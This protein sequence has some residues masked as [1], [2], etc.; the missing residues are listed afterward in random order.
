MDVIFEEDK[1]FWMAVN[2]FMQN[3]KCPIVLIS[4]GQRLPAVVTKYIMIIPVVIAELH[5]RSA[6]ERS[7][8]PSENFW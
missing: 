1:S 6:L 5:A 4:T 7:P 2:S 3:A 8:Y